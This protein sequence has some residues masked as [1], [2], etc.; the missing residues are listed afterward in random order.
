M[1][2]RTDIVKFLLKRGA[3]VKTTNQAQM[4]PL[5][6]A[7]RKGHWEI[8]DILLF[9]RASLVDVDRHGRTP[10]ML[11]AGEGHL[12]VLE[13]LL[14][15]GESLFLSLSGWTLFLSVKKTVTKCELTRSCFLLQ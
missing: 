7:V 9:H 13:I 15:K 5:I 4:T 6:C 1:Q 8:V 2:G 3:S 14:S 11:A 12:A 10:L